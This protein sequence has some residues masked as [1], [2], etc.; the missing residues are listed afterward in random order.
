MARWRSVLR[1]ANQQLRRL[2]VHGLYFLPALRA[3]LDTEIYPISIEET[4]ASSHPVLRY[5]GY[6]ES[7]DRG[8]SIRKQRFCGCL[9]QALD[10]LCHP[11]GFSPDF[12]FYYGAALRFVFD[13]N[14]QIRG[15][16][17]ATCEPGYQR[18]L[19]VYQDRTSWIAGIDP[20]PLTSNLQPLD[21]CFS[22]DCLRFCRPGLHQGRVAF[23]TAAFSLLR[24]RL[25]LPYQCGV[26]QAADAKRPES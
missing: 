9:W 19:A 21:G 10:D 17:V 20:T 7:L 5:L 2:V 18:H 13:Q 1:R 26:C 8:S 12:R 15:R 14:I 25:S 24:D 23:V 16:P 3:I 4:L 6:R 22:P 11:L